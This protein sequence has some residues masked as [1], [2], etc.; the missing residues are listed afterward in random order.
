M[1]EDYQEDNQSQ[2]TSDYDTNVD[3]DETYAASNGLVKAAKICEIFM[4]IGIVVA[5]IGFLLFIFN[6]GDAMDGYSKDIVRCEIGFSCFVY[7]GI[8]ALSAFILT[9]V[10]NGLSVMTMASEYYLSK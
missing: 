10:L 3:Y 4:W 7:C 5:A 1:E 8:G 9:K 6:I 2:Y